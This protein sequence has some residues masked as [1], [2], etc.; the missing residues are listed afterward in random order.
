[1]TSIKIEVQDTNLLV[2]HTIVGGVTRQ[3]RHSVALMT[4]TTSCCGKLN[5]LHFTCSVKFSNTMNNTY[6][7]ETSMYES[8]HNIKLLCMKY[9]VKCFFYQNKRHRYFVNVNIIVC[10]TCETTWCHDLLE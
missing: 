10:E 4:K 5:V 6:K 3:S 7:V 1:M 9:N 2:Y 8:E